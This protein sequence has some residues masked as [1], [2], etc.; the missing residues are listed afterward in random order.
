MTNIAAKTPTF[1]SLTMNPVY[2]RRESVRAVI[3][4]LHATQHRRHEGEFRVTTRSNE[5]RIAARTRAKHRCSPGTTSFRSKTPAP[6]SKS[7]KLPV[8]LRSV[9]R[10]KL[11]DDIMLIIAYEGSAFD[12]E[13]FVVEAD[14]DR[15]RFVG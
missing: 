13:T 11:F 6:S 8:V 10:F 9:E 5:E 7:L 15:D 12:G 3:D 14:K 2:F 1:L 4:E